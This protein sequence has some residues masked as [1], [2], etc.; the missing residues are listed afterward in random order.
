MDKTVVSIK[1]CPYTEVMAANTLDL[2]ST[3]K[4]VIFCKIKHK[5]ELE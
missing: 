2:S 1:N 4:L 5:N 3:I